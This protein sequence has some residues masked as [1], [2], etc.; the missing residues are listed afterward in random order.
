MSELYFYANVNTDDLVS[1]SKQQ[2]QVLEYNKTNMLFTA[3]SEKWMKYIDETRKYSTYIKY[4]KIY[5]CHLQKSL[6][7][8]YM[9]DIT[10]EFISQ[11][12][13]ESNDNQEL[14]DNIKY[15]ILAIVN[16]ILKYANEYCHCPSINLSNRYSQD[17]KN[18]IEI[19]NHTDQS[20]LLKYLYRDID[21]SKVGIIICISMGLRLG[22]I[23]SLKWEDIDLA[24]MIIHVKSTVQRI[25]LLNQKSK[26]A[27]TTTS[28]KSIFSVREIPIFKD[29]KELLVQLKKVFRNM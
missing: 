11:K 28:P 9:S 10:N 13:F 21:I 18:H 3:V 29:L 12:I 8:A 23:Y 6:Q 20:L 14:S 27:L 17:R 2:A 4:L 5:Q 16:Q 19:I 25:T 1:K 15:S 22:K 7:K 26:T 24:Q